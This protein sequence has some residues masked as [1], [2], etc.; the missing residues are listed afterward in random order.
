ML[1]VACYSLKQVLPNLPNLPI[2]DSG[3]NLGG[4]HS[5]TGPI[6]LMFTWLDQA[7]ESLQSAIEVTSFFYFFFTRLRKEDGGVTLNAQICNTDVLL[8]G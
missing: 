4:Y 8:A 5:N 1:P 2:F 3:K 6:K 7:Y